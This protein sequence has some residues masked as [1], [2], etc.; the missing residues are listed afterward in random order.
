MPGLNP[1]IHRLAK[2]LD[3]RD[4]SRSAV[5][6]LPGHD[7]HS[8][9]FDHG[10]PQTAS[11]SRRRHRPRSDGRGEAA[12]R[13]AERAGIASFETEDGLVG[14]SS[15][16]ADKVAITDATMAK[17]HASDAV[18]FGAVGGAEMGRGAL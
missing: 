3:G 15:Y 2:K 8:E 4:T 6:P 9:E 12:D 16:D 10:D 17:A 7:Y 1:G 5:A 14:G 13:L 11:S 18:I